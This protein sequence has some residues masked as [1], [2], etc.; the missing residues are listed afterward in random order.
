MLSAE[1]FTQSAKC[2]GEIGDNVYSRCDQ[3]RLWQSVCSLSSV[4]LFTDYKN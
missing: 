4:W 3:C 2:V 1:I